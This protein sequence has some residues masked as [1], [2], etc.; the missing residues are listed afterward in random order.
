MSPKQ[1]KSARLPII[2]NNKARH[3]Y[4]LGDRYEA[5]IVLLGTE[6]EINKAEATHRFLNLFARI[7]KSEL[8]I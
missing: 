7:I 1:S 5:G 3:K 4:A 6:G 2:A 8:F